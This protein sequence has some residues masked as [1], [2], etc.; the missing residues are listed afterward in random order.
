MSLAS[1][2]PR[3]FK[4]GSTDQAEH[5]PLR[6]PEHSAAKDSR[7]SAHHGG[8]SQR[9][10]LAATHL[11][12]RSRNCGGRRP[13]LGGRSHVFRCRA[14][15]QD[16]RPT[17]AGGT[18]RVALRKRWPRDLGTKRSAYHEILFRQTDMTQ[19]LGL[20]RSGNSTLPMFRAGNH[21]PRQLSNCCEAGVFVGRHAPEARLS[22]GATPKQL[23]APARRCLEGRRPL[24]S[25][26]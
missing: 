1:R 14:A 19:G 25:S 26:V 11:G 6:S 17:A 9:R 20:N 18:R 5:E 3:R 24:H 15:V 22:D 7:M 10:L 4:E 13:L 16:D 23:L 12:G 2:N 8:R 21:T